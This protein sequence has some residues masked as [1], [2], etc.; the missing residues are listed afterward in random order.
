[1][2]AAGIILAISLSAV[3]VVVVII[4]ANICNKATDGIRNKYIDAKEKRN[5]PKPENLADRYK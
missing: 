1:M 2:S 3:L 4:I 5:P